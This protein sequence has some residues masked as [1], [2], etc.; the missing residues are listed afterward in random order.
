MKH[1]ASGLVV[2]C[3]DDLAARYQSQGWV[4]ADADTQHVEAA[5]EKPQP[6]KRGRTKKS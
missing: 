5:P 6:V 3:G 2:H 4:D 1:P